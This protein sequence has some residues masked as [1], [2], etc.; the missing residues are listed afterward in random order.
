MKKI[1]D[2]ISKSRLARGVLLALLL[3]SAILLSIL[4]GLF[5]KIDHQILNH[6]YTRRPAQPID[7][8]ITLWTIYDDSLALSRWPWSW[9]KFAESYRLLETHGARFGMIMENNFDQPGKITMNRDAA[10]KLKGDLKSKISTAGADDPGALLNVL[11]QAV[12]DPNK[13]FIEQLRRYPHAMLSHNFVIPNNQADTYVFEEFE[14]RK[15]RFEPEKIRAIEAIKKF[16]QPWD[17]PGRL[18]KAID[19]VPLMPELT[20]VVAGVGFNRIIPDGDGAV[21]RAP[22]LVYYDGMIYFSQGIVAAAHELGCKLADI[23]VIPGKHLRFKGVSTKKGAGE[24]TVPIDEYGMMYI[25]WSRKEQ[26]KAFN[27]YPFTLTQNFIAF[28]MMKRVVPR[29]PLDNPE[30]IPAM[31]ERFRATVGQSGQADEGELHSLAYRALML[32]IIQTVV[33]QQGLEFALG[34]SLDMLFDSMQEHYQPYFGIK[35]G[36]APEQHLYFEDYP[37][38]CQ[39]MLINTLAA[40][41]FASGNDIAFEDIADALGMSGNV[42]SVYHLQSVK[43]FSA[44]IQ[45]LIDSGQ[46][47]PIPGFSHSEDRDVLF[48]LKN[49]DL[50]ESKFILELVG[51]G[52]VESREQAE[53]TGLLTLY[54]SVAERQAYLRTGYT[55]TR[56]YQK[57]GQLEQVLPLYFQPS[58]KLLDADFERLISPASL[59][60][61]V[62]FVGLT[63]TGLNSLNPTPYNQREPMAGMTPTILNTILTETFIHPENGQLEVVLVIAGTLVILLLTLT[64]PIYISLPIFLALSYGHYELSARLFE[65][66][67]LIIPVF[68]PLLAYVL[69]FVG[70]LLYEYWEQQKERQQIRSMFAA[71]VSPEV[72]KIME[73]D[74]DQFK[75]QGTKVEASMFSS[76]VSGFTTISEGVTAEE[77]ARILNLYLTPMSNLVMTYGGYVEKYEGDAIKA[78]F[79]LP[80]PDP[81]HT[82]KACYSALLQQEELWGVQRMLQLKYGVMIK[83]RMGI[84]TGTV[85]A[86]NMGS[87]N[88]MQYCALG[89]AVA[90]AEEL[91]PSNKMWETW[92][93]IGPETYQQA[94]DYVVTRFLDNVIYAHETVPVYEVLGWPAEKFTTYWKGKPIPA[95]VIEGWEKIIPEKVL[96]YIDYYK[97]KK[98][99]D[100][101]FKQAF[102]QACG[103]LRQVCIEYVKLMSKIDVCRVEMEYQEL[104][105]KLGEFDRNK[106]LSQLSDIDKGDLARYEKTAAEATD[107][108]RKQIAIYQFELRKSYYVV[109]DLLGKVERQVYNNY[110]RIVDSLEKRVVCFLKRVQF[111]EPGDEVGKLFA[112]DLKALLS[113]PGGGTKPEELA[114]LE[115]RISDILAQVKARMVQFSAKAKAMAEDYHLF[116]AEHCRV[117]AEKSRVIETFNQGRKLYLEK[118][119]AEAKAVF[120]QGLASVPDDGPCATFAKRCEQF[121]KSPPPADWKG[122]WVANF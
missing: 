51:A 115:K 29:E 26:M 32:W 105:K 96:A 5:D 17:R 57:R 24:L 122:D 117:P 118:R 95:L 4:F 90:M 70:A 102:T 43:G 2:L 84:N 15:R 82:W 61:Q 11:T 46:F 91:E 71:M 85:S 86:G 101:A 53:K 121:Q 34:E 45:P 25:N 33:K 41:E 103:D 77:L 112:E 104:I 20:E 14:N 48:G 65:H 107:P 106:I 1:L 108:W 98:L 73:E 59:R 13:A 10:Q 120:E 109:A 62:V 54:R 64:T 6:F 8:R 56:E 66:K 88:K 100:L 28:D 23:E 113:Q 63:A 79:G 67:G 27:T 52:L 21:R 76:D 55:L 35:E 50:P 74:P 69:G 16:G 99:P 81:D 22:T 92:I 83:A 42:F 110:E 40:G 111:P 89:E 9:D 68:A 116:M 30:L 44:E 39:S 78:D 7:E 36:G 114:A 87:E 72:L 60:D 58:N 49:S 119:F 3:A 31:I 12:P 93:A 47:K 37:L 75:L 94:K 97:F 38:I 18:I 19:V 80:I